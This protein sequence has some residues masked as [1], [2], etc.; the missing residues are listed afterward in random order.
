MNFLNLNTNKKLIFKKKL[1]IFIEKLY[2]H[3]QTVDGERFQ[4]WG[5]SHH[6]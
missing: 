5:L 6:A 1:F 3:C 4:R 2:E